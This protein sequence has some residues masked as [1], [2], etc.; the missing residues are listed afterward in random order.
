MRLLRTI[1]TKLG[2]VRGKTL[3][4]V[5]TTVNAEG[6]FITLRYSTQFQ[7]GPAVE[8]FNWQLDGDSAKLAGYFIKRDPP[9][10]K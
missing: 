7:H 6:T 9:A 1:H 10:K 2:N 8:T 3:D 5:A 4:S